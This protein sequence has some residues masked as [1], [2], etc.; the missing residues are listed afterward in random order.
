MILSKHSK[1][2]QNKG[3][4]HRGIAAS[5]LSA[6][7]PIASRYLF[8]SSN[9]EIPQGFRT[10][11]ND[12]PRSACSGNRSCRLGRVGV[13]RYVGMTTKSLRMIFPEP[14]KCFCEWRWSWVLN[15]STSVQ[16]RDLAT[17][18][19]NAI[20]WPQTAWVTKWWNDHLHLTV[21]YIQ[22]TKTCHRVWLIWLQKHVLKNHATPKKMETCFSK[23]ETTKCQVPSAWHHLFQSFEIEDEMRLGV[24]DCGSTHESKI[25][26][27]ISYD[28]KRPENL[29]RRGSVRSSCGK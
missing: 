11:R 29:G 5:H 8:R 25:P 2:K 4:Q 10:R 19:L 1:I 24:L 3:C 16:A 23:E 6:S 12:M 28:W 22:Q 14:A 18:R 13:F 27:M 15:R 26:M 9:R 21:L 17:W 20:C 7:W